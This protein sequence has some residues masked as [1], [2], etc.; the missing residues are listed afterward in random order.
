MVENGQIQMKMIKIAFSDLKEHSN[1]KVEENKAALEL[2]FTHDMMK[3]TSWRFKYGQKWQKMAK[4]GQKLNKLN[5]NAFSDLKKCS[6][7]KIEENKSG[8][9]L[10]FT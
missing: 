2:N 6:N 5:K 3:S 7:Q 4:N 1:E 9:K 8:L 10:N